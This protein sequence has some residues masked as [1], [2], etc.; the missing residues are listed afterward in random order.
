MATQLTLV[1]EV[2]QN[3]VAAAT[4]DPRFPSVTREETAEVHISVDV[5]AGQEQVEGVEQ[6]DPT[7]YGVIVRAGQRRGV[8]LPDIAQVT[9]ADLQ[10]AIA[11][12]KAGIRPDT[13]ME[14][15]RFE[16][17]RSQGEPV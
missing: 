3:V 14:I 2:I 5:L 10:V 13:V 17:V 11:R 16:V 1:Q 4:A 8:L 6:L 15:Y 9:T 12:Q 7:C